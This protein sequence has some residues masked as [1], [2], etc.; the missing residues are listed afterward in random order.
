MLKVVPVRK[1]LST[2]LLVLVLAW[3]LVSGLLFSAVQILFDARAQSRDIDL[4]AE[5]ALLGLRQA[6]AEAAYEIDAHLAR[7]VLDGLAA[8]P[9]VRASRLQLHPDMLLGDSS[10]PL[11]DGRGRQL[12]DRLFDSE[13]HYSIDLPD[14]RGGPPLGELSVVIDTYVEGRVF[15]D[16][17]MVA[18]LTGLLWA[19]MLGLV[20]SA[21]AQSLVT[22]PLHRLVQSLSEIAQDDPERAKIKVSARHQHDEIGTLA[23]ELERLLL[24]V[25]EQLARRNEAEAQASFLR[26]FDELTGLPNRR[27]LISRISHALN[28][29]DG[30]EVAV[31]LLDV[32]GFRELNQ[33]HGS[34]VGDQVLR[35]LG[36]RFEQSC[37]GRGFAARLGQDVFAV[38]VPGGPTRT[39]LKD[40]AAAAQGS[41]AEPVELENLSLQ[42]ATWAGAAL[43]PDDAD[44]PESLV[45]GAES[46]LRQARQS[47]Q[48]GLQFYSA[49]RDEN[50]ALRRRL[51]NDLRSADLPGQLGLVFEPQL[52]TRDERV[53][54]IEAL[55]RWQHPF[56]GELRPLRFIGIAEDN[57]SIHTLGTWVL[58][59]ACAQAVRWRDQFGR[60]LKVAVNVSAAQLRRRG[61]ES[62]VAR[63]LQ[64]S[65]LPG[66]ALELEITETALVEDMQ[67][68]ARTLKR[69][70]ELGVGIA[71]DDFGTG[72][73]SLGYLKSLPVTRL[74]ID[75][76]F[77]RDV[78]TDA[79]DAAIVRAIIGLGHSL[80]LRVTAE[81]IETEAQRQL[82]NA[83]GCDDLQGMLFGCALPADQIS[84]ALQRCER[85][86]AASRS[87][88]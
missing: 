7:Q 63:A 45:Q 80:G 48:T 5:R 41:W 11:V 76:S 34:A 26:E 33:V 86:P 87:V 88:A 65:G 46:A 38:L 83:L 35:T 82:L 44:G 64:E 71:I 58:N 10:K 14:P 70:R 13:R 55:V 67:H 74:K 43:Y 28:N 68:A 53:L 3:A 37:A 36:Q 40:L 25:R 57:G 9:G 8:F 39:S 66:E 51:S 24:A 22:R 77:V 50:A 72:H 54:G 19:L 31:L 42:I 17:A 69:V 6:A 85:Q 79:S 52:S 18:L 29:A 84:A 73:A 2:R 15:L 49:G 78:L 20:V 81:G 56:L 32:R 1:R 75:M 60:P 59:A 12:S 27:L 30:H 47:G 4:N 16:R 23:G 62:I 61:F 21:V